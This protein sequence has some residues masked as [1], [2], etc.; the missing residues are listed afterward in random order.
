MSDFEERLKKKL[1][2]REQQRLAK[3]SDIERAQHE[4]NQWLKSNPQAYLNE[5]GTVIG[6]ED[7][8]DEWSYDSKQKY[9]EMA[10][11]GIVREMLSTSSM[12]NVTL[13]A[14]SY[15]LG[16]LAAGLQLPVEQP[17]LEL[18]KAAAR[19]GLQP[20]EIAKTLRSGLTKGLENP[21]VK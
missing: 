4:Y 7:F 14:L 17:A 15:R 20:Y 19:T 11:E 8:T 6:L 2:E 9:Y 5:D 1:A 13:N 10:V 18:A 16:R 3:M 21:V 12:R